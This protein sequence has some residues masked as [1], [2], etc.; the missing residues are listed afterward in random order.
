ML[1][2]FQT[3]CYMQGRRPPDQAAQSH[4]QPGLECLHG[5]GIHSLLGQPVQCVT[6]LCVK[7]FLLISILNLPSQFKTIPPCPITTHLSDLLG[8]W[9]H[10]HSASY[11]PEHILSTQFTAITA[12]YPIPNSVPP[13]H[14]LRGFLHQFFTCAK[15]PIHCVWMYKQA[16][17]QPRVSFMDHSCPPA[18]Q[19][20]SAQHTGKQTAS[21]R[22]KKS[23][24]HKVAC[25]QPTSKSSPP[26]FCG[27]VVMA[28]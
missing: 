4:I 25:S 9:P 5:W 20:S 10:C 22:V 8:F 24:D 1:I 26:L 6:T 11:L 7:K 16:Q 2:Q 19:N 15:F 27:A 28:R 23:T 17:G 13:Q 21:R 14:Y 12:T 18:V 3:S